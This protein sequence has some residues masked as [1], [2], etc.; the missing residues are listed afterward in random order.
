MIYTLQ[1]KERTEVHFGKY[2]AIIRFAGSEFG[3]QQLLEFFRIPFGCIT[4]NR[5]PQFAVCMECY[6][7]ESKVIVHASW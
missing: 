1:W 2:Q 6:V 3:C 5:K 4:C 7:V